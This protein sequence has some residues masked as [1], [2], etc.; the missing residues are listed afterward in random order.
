MRVHLRPPDLAESRRAALKLLLFG[1]PGIA[2]CAH[3]GHGGRGVLPAAQSNG[4]SEAQFPSAG[5]RTY[6]FQ[7]QAGKPPVVVLHEI[8]GLN[9]TCFALGDRLWNSGF[10]V[11]LPLL[12]GNRGGHSFL[13]GYFR[14]CGSSQFSCAS[15]H[16]S[17]AIMPSLQAF[18]E[19]VSA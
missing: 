13:G 10:S 8:L 3:A 11:F 19:H 16:R 12:F 4:W 17:S 5:G 6:F 2:A 15:P 18:C 1:A 7:K 9:D 14:S